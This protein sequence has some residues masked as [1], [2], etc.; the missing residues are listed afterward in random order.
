MSCTTNAELKKFILAPLTGKVVP[1]EQ[2]PDAV[3]SQKI[4]GAGVAIIP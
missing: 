4:L 2:M 3:F 1:L